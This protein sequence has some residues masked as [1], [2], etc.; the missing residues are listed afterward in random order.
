MYVPLAALALVAP[1]LLPLVVSVI[2]GDAVA[3][4][5]D[6]GT[7]R[8]ML[9]WPAGRTRLVIIKYLV[10]LTFCAAAA[11][12][13]VA[14]GLAAGGAFF[15]LAPLVTSSGSSIGLV[16]GAMRVVLAGGIVTAN[17][18]TVAAIGMFASTLTDSPLGAAAAAFGAFI[19][20]T[21]LDGISQ[22]A[23]IHPLLFTHYSLSFTS[24]V[25]ASAGEAAE[26]G[27]I[28][29]LLVQLAYVAVFLASAVVV[30]RR[31]DVL[32]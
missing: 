1:L 20:S 30:F 11:T 22:L 15:G 17:M 6:I 13:M 7:L 26:T 12:A 9:A 2:G 16:S 23:V 10:V 32:S 29:D 25:G 19:I 31:R 24:V 27:V 28:A 4:D 18:A 5:A 8:Y 21:V 14:A 3:G